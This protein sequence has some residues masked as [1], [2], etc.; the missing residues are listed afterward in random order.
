MY[1]QSFISQVKSENQPA[2]DTQVGRKFCPKRLSHR[3]DLGIL[4]ADTLSGVTGQR[5]SALGQLEN[6]ASKKLRSSLRWR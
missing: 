2:S 6:N 5:V 1:Q 3:E 4:A